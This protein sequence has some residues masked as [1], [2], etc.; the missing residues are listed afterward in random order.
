VDGIAVL[1]GLAGFERNRFAAD[2]AEFGRRRRGRH[3][4]LLRAQRRSEGP[5]PESFGIYYAGIA[6]T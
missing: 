4:I 1:I 2:P 6:I 3:K 5:E